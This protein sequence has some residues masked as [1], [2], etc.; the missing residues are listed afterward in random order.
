MKEY[1]VISQKDK[2]FSGRFA[3][4]TIQ[5]VL[6][7]QARQGWE[8]K[9]VTTAAREGLLHGGGKDEV[10]LILERDTGARKEAVK[11][12]MAKTFGSDAKPASAPPKPPAG[13]EPEVYQL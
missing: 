6:N 2:W 11:A 7:E 4:E 10:I 3:P 1:K 8:L 12:A 9:A 13:G 5:S